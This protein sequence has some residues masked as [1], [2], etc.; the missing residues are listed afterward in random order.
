MHNFREQ[1]QHKCQIDCTNHDE[2]IN[3]LEIKSKDLY[4]FW[5][6]VLLYF[7]EE[8]LVAL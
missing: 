5:V 3:K 6:G 2:V 7:L 4:Y 8:L 1:N